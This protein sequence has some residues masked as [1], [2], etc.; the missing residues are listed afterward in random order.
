M[1]VLQLIDSLQPGGAERVA[2]NI[3]NGLESYIDKSFLCATRSEGE[4][5]NAISHNVE[6][7][8]LKKMH[9]LDL[10]AIRNLNVY[11]KRNKIDIIHAHSSS[12]FL[13]TIIKLFNR[14]IKLVWH[15]HYGNSEFL[16]NRKS[17]ILKLLSTYFDFIICVNKNLEKWTRN[18]LKVKSVKYLPNF[19]VKREINPVTKLS[20]ESNKRIICL[21]NLRPQKDHLTLLRAFKNVVTEFSDWTLHLVGKDFKDE[22]SQIVKSEISN[23]NLSNAAIIYGSKQDVFPILKQCDIG[24]LTSKSEGLPIA[25]LEYGLANLPVLTTDVGE[26]GNVIGNKNNGIV[27]NSQD[28]KAIYKG[29]KFYIENENKRKEMADSF[30]EKV[31][32]EFSQEAVINSINLIYNQIL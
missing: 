1:R 26:C 31:L 15:D 24:I 8:Y 9:T 13:A 4:L 16:K 17:V 2:V 5:K 21:A 3:A 28:E 30:T 10:R 22:Y 29:I 6:Y 32:S 7:I 11:I 25:L 23:L 12:F 27:V 19:A 18:Y 20:G 14:K